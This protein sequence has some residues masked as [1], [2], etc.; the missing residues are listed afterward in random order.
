MTINTQRRVALLASAILI[1]VPATAQTAAGNPGGQATDAT[2]I[3]QPDAEPQNDIIV[4]GQRRL[5]RAPQDAK[6]SSLA[7][8]DSVGALEIQKLPDQTVADALAGVPGVSLQRGFQFQKGWYAT[9]RGLD[10]NYNSVDLDGGMFFDSTRNDRAVYLDCQRRSKSRPAWRSK[11]RPL[12]A[13]AD[14]MRRAPIGA[15]LIS[16]PSPIWRSG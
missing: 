10:S 3:G 12:E 8:V 2:A 14:D 9:I 15:L 6:R 16:L 13:C 1:A 5:S 7:M 4:T 11:S